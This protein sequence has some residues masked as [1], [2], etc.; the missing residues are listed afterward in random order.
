MSSSNYSVLINRFITDSQD[1]RGKYMRKV[2]IIK[3][4]CLMFLLGGCA[5]EQARSADPRIDQAPMTTET[6]KTSRDYFNK[7]NPKAFAF[8]PEKGTNWAVWGYPP[9]E[10][11]IKQA[12][13]ECEE[14]TRTR[15]VLF[16]VNDQIVWQPS[17]E[18]QVT[19]PEVKSP[20]F[21]IQVAAVHDLAE[22]PG[23]WKRLT[24]RYQALADLE[25]QA[26][27]T[28]EVPGK[29]TFYRVIGGSF[30][31]RAEAQTVCERLRLAGGACMIAE[32]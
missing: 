4:L 11:A 24:R 3:E 12:M 7:P 28:I 5:A 25:L 19:E 31:T 32:L 2:E 20:R 13:Q 9:V 18:H 1:S 30:E 15:C 8:S 16:A 10:A 22:I 17:S 21:A 29:G 27:K 23:E 14:R 6:K 26:P